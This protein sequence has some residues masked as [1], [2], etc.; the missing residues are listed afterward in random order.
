MEKT[1]FFL[2][3]M[4]LERS[5]VI[6]PPSSAVTQFG[7]V[8]KLYGNYMV[9]CSGDVSS[10][11]L[12]NGGSNTFNE[13]VY[14][15]QRSRVGVWELKQTFRAVDYTDL[16]SL[17][18]NNAGLSCR[19][20]FGVNATIYKNYLAIGQWNQGTGWANGGATA[21]QPGLVH[22]FVRNNDG[23]WVLSQTLTGDTP[24]GQFG[25][26]VSLSDDT[27]VV[28]ENN[29]QNDAGVALGAAYWYTRD[30]DG[31]YQRVDK[32]FGENDASQYGGVN[33]GLSG[34]Q[35]IVSAIDHT[36][37]GRAN[38]G[39]VYFY[40]RDNSGQWEETGSDAG[41]LIGERLGFG[42]SK[43][44]K[45]YAIVGSSQA[46]NT[47]GD[48]A[49]G[50][51]KIYVRNISGEWVIDSEIQGIS[52]GDQ[53][54][55]PVDLYGNYFCMGSAAPG[56]DQ[57]SIRFFKRNPVGGYDQSEVLLFNSTTDN[58]R[59]FDSLS[60]YGNY[61]SVGA[62]NIVAGGAAGNFRGLVHFIHNK[63]G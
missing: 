42:G 28:G 58:V 54:G 62:P 46:Q 41:S 3:K 38:A 29:G 7:R 10:P 59:G 19:T 24:N 27:L 63:T 56:N 6:E 12:T 9:V 37:D 50:T 25:I 47:A 30:N 31:I 13:I 4:V 23:I 26:T 55:S 44:Y 35:A 20:G 16:R 2:I 53:L 11:Q 14:F 60:M 15:Y 17:P 43:I 34:N 36:Q 57:S 21:T 1:F 32:K 51:V 33:I 61:I 39:K 40:T 22:I 48:G 49:A 45:N 18:T 52:A 5:A 8:T